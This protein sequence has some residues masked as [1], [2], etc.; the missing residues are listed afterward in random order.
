MIG[1]LSVQTDGP[2][3]WYPD[4]PYYV[5]TYHL[6]LDDR[7]VAHVAASRW[8]PPQLSLRQLLALEEELTTEQPEKPCGRRTETDPP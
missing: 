8:R 2:W 3:F 4:L 6:A 1:A 5:E 7:F